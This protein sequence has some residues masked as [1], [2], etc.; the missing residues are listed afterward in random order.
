LIASVAVSPTPARN[1]LVVEALHV[2]MSEHSR[3]DLAPGD[4]HVVNS[5]KTVIFAPRR[6]GL[7]GIM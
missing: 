6:R 3:P 1:R 5:I 2:G 4:M 7:S